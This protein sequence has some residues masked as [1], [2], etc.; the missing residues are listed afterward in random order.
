MPQRSTRNSGADCIP[1]PIRGP[2]HPSGWPPPRR[3]RT[4][5]AWLESGA[6]IYQLTNLMAQHIRRN[7]WEKVAEGAASTGQKADRQQ[8]RIGREVYVG[9]TPESARAEAR[10]VLGRP[11]NEHQYVNRQAQGTLRYVKLESSHAR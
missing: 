2:I 6:A 10:I 11:F 5:S 7:F 1:G 3:I 4:P 8:L 9:E